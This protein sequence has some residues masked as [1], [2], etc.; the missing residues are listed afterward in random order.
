MSGEAVLAIAVGARVIARARL[1]DLDHVGTLV[2]QDH[3]GPRPGQHRGQVDNANSL[4]RSEVSHHCTL[5]GSRSP[6]GRGVQ[7]RPRAAGG[8]YSPNTSVMTDKSATSCWASLASG[9]IRLN[10]TR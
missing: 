9:L 8:P 1:F 3:G 5:C 10:Y 6:S 7:P 4:E 2:G